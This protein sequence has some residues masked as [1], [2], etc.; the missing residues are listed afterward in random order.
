MSILLFIPITSLS[1]D[2]CNVVLNVSP[3]DFRYSVDLMY[4][5]RDMFGTYNAFGE[6]ITTRH[7]GHGD[8]INLWGNDVREVYQTFELR[9]N[10]YFFDKWRTT[11]ILPY[12]YNIQKINDDVRYQVNALGDPMLLQS[13]RVTNTMGDTANQR[14]TQRWVVGAGLR[15]PIGQTQMTFDNGTPNLDLQPGSGAWGNLFYSVLTIKYRL[16]RW[17]NNISFMHNG[18]DELNYQYGQTINWTSNLFLDIQLGKTTLRLLGG[19]YYEDAK[20]D[21]TRS[22]GNEPGLIHDNTGGNIWFVQ[23]GIRL[24]T[25]NMQFFG[26]YEHAAKSNLNGFEQLLTRRTMNIGTTWYF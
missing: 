24:F 9:G 3:N 23:S 10:Y 12:V 22:A 26:T 25:K 13:Y 14:F 4:R 11:I 19:L 7:A 21:K 6:M 1:C 2:H 20:M 15:A 18:K 5:S 16:A 17:R 8:D